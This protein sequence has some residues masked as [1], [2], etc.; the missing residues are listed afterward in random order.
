MKKLILLIWVIVTIFILSSCDMPWQFEG[1]S[2]KEWSDRYYAENSD[3]VDLQNLYDTLGQENEDL[4]VQ[5]DDLTAEYDD[6]N[7]RYDD[8]NSC[9]DDAY[10]LEEAKDCL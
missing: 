8:L 5:L 6:L 10:D 4:K 2:A 1:K 7:S 3:K 9:V